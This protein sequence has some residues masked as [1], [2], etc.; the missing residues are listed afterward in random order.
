[1][2]DLGAANRI[3]V[4]RISRDRS[5]HTLKLSQAEYAEKVLGCFHMK[6]AK[7]STSDGGHATTDGGHTTGGDHGKAGCL[8]I[9]WLERNDLLWVPRVA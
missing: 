1:M 6:G 5:A 3:L 9:A 2:K 7:A 4:M 8:G